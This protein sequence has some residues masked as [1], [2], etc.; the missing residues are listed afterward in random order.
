MPFLHRLIGATVSVVALLQ[1]GA[2][3]AD[4]R[5]EP[6]PQQWRQLRMLHLP[7]SQWQFMDAIRTDRLEAA[8]YIRAPRLQRNTVAFDAGLLLRKSG[9]EIWT[10]RVLPMRAV[11]ADD[12]LERLSPDGT[13]SS[14]PGRPD[15][16]VK[17]RWICALP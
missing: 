13:W 16:V 12:R 5:P 2:V 1:G 11:C 3:R 15:T 6:E 8:E 17:V 7:E 10:S 4:W 14:Y 9:Q